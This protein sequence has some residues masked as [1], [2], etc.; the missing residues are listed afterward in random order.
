[1]APRAPSIFIFG[2][3]NSFAKCCARIKHAYSFSCRT[4][5]AIA[6]RDC[7]RAGVA[8]FDN[9]FDPGAARQPFH[10]GS[11]RSAEA[12]LFDS[13]TFQGCPDDRPFLPRPAAVAAGLVCV[14][15]AVHAA[16]AGSCRY[17]PVATLPLRAGGNPAQP[18]VDGTINGKPAIMLIDTGMSRSVLLKDSAEK[19][20]IALRAGGHSFGIGGAAN[21]YVAHV[22]DFS[23]GT[24]HSGKTDMNVLGNMGMQTPFDAI[25]GDDFSLQ[26]DLEIALGEKQFRFFRATGC[27]DT[28]LAYW[29]PDAMEI[30]FGGTETGHRNP[31]LIVEINGSKMEAMF[32]TGAT[33][34]VMTRAAADAPASRST[35][36]MW[37]GPAPAAASATCA[38]TIGRP[39]STPSR[40]AA[41]PSATPASASWIIRRKG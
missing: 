29:S 2:K 21:S 40:S 16:D 33:S 27:Q 20:G 15:P 14:A 3:V 39:T 1:M 38:S 25:I 13:P 19:L 30:P 7:P 26:M 37:S 6:C 5:S 23:V 4:A 34:T 31:R 41:K 24:A 17:V 32:D 9:R 12:P 8:G 18:T 35:H 28:Y 36:R 10:T 11:D 22:T